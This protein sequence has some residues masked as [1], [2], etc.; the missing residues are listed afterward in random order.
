[1]IRRLLTSIFFGFSFCIAWAQ[2]VYDNGVFVMNE[3]W[4]GHCNSTIN[5]IDGKGEWIYDIIGRENPGKELGS[6]VSYGTIYGGRFYII[7][8]QDKDGGT[9]KEG[10]RITV[11]DART[12]KIIKQI[13]DIDDTGVRADGRGFVVVNSEKAYV[14]SNNGIYILNLSNFEIEGKIEGTGNEHTDPYGSMYLGQ[15]GTLIRINEK[16]YALHQDKGLMIIDPYTDKVT[17]TMA[18]PDNG[19]LTYGSA[20]LSKDG[21]LWLSVSDKFSRGDSYNYIMRYT[22]S[23][24]DTLRVNMPEGVSSPS[25]SWYAWTPDGFCASTK[26]NVL[27]WNTG[28]GAWYSNYKI[29][30]YDI[31]RNEFS[32]FLD[33]ESES[34]KVYGSSMRVDPVSSNLYVTLYKDPAIPYFTMRKYDSTGT[35]LA[36]YEM[37]EDYWYP[38]I[39][40]FP[41]NASPI[42]QNIEAVNISDSKPTVI[43]LDDIAAD[44]DN[45]SAAMV[46]TITEVT[47]ESVISADIVNGSLHITPLNDGSSTVVIDINSNGKSTSAEVAVSITGYN[48]IDNTAANISTAYITGGMLHINNCEGTEFRLYDINGCLADSFIASSSNFVRNVNLPKGLYVLYGK[49]TGEDIVLKLNIR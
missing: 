36:E 49:Q 10:A 3:G 11:C 30:K 1:M 24:G 17:D 15:T 13:K 43:N 44:D 37:K 5:F 20:V 9:D 48:G 41:D 8:K 33:F 34:L 47:D 19:K 32:L 35:K 2:N 39:Q 23:T 4:F 14:G 26:Q 22:P 25:N 42:A 6:T 12:M 7:T 16:V 45:M 46:K 40:V 27:Y 18:G 28:D 21:S 38:S 31:D 29:Y